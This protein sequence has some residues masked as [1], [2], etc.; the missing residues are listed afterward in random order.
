MEVSIGYSVTLFVYIYNVFFTYS[1]IPPFHVRWT[2]GTQNTI[3]RTYQNSPFA[4][5]KLWSDLLSSPAPK[6]MSGDNQT[7]RTTKRMAQRFR[8]M[9][10]R[11][12]VFSPNRVCNCWHLSFHI[13]FDCLLLFNNRDDREHT[14]FAIIWIYNMVKRNVRGGQPSP[15]PRVPFHALRAAQLLSSI[16]VSGIMCYF[17]YYLRK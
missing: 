11:R 8:I 14:A 16:V 9:C 2:L 4:W 17:M 10:E 7:L 3:S 15:Y 1:L 5:F 12:M 6:Q 13:L